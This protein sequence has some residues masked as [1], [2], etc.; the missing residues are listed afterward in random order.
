ML[1]S[2]AIMRSSFRMQLKNLAEANCF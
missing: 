1:E 2:A